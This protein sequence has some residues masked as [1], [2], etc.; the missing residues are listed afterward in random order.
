MT[1]MTPESLLKRMMLLD[2]ESITK[3]EEL[4]NNIHEL[5]E[6]CYELAAFIDQNEA[7]PTGDTGPTCTAPHART[8]RRGA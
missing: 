2:G 8:N 1:S 3:L 5:R 6:I 4:R 7:P